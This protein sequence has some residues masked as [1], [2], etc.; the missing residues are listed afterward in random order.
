MDAKE[1]KR[2]ELASV[3]KSLFTEFGYK[4]VSMDQ[5]AQK[6][7]VAKGTLYLYFKDK[8]Q[9][10]TYLF[11]H[12]LQPIWEKAE[13][14]RGK[15]LPILDEI[16]Q[17]IYSFLMYRN[18][19]KFL[20]K[21]AQEAKELGTPSACRA[22]KKIDDD[23]LAYLDHRLQQAAEQKKLRPFNTTILSFIIIKVYT[24]LAFEW[25]EEHEKLNEE[26][27]ANSVKLFLKDGLIL[28]E[29]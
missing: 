29:G 9:I 3:A 24:A 22:V 26:E 6:A 20:Y 10:L 15:G 23:I 12:V 2:Q 1:E 21:I 7:Q 14:I 18:N 28:H 5:I 17:V 11:K 16:H 4:C 8:E 27:I 25:E 19:Q 13:E